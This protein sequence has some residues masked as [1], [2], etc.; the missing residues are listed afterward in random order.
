[1]AAIDWQT[2]ERVTVLGLGKSGVSVV[3][4]LVA[5]FADRLAAGSL[6]IQVLDSRTEPPGLAQA[7]QLLGAQ[8]IDCRRW[9][10]EDTLA[11]DL[12]VISPGVDS[13][14]ETIFLARQVGVQVVGDVELFA[15][16]NQQPCVGVT[17]SNGKSTVTRMVEFIAQQQGKNIVAAGNIGYPVLDALQQNV[18]GYV[19]EL[20]SF[21]LETTESLQLRAATVLNVSP[22]HL[23]R[24]QQLAD[25]A[26][27]KQ[28]IYRHA[29]CRVLN[30]Q[31]RQYW[32]QDTNNSVTFGDDE[33]A[34]DFALK[35]HQSELWV[36][37]QGDLLVGAHQLA[38]Q[39]LHNLL[40]V[41]AALA[42]AMGL[43]ID[44]RDAARQIIQFKGLPHRCQLVTHHAGIKWVNDSKATNVGATEAAISGLRPVVQGRLIVIMGGVGKGADFTSLQPALQQV[45]AL[46][47]IG[48]E[49]PAIGALF[50]GS[51]Q[52][53]S[54]DA[55]VKLA[56]SLAAD[57]DMVLLSPACASFDQFDDFE[58]RGQRFEQA[59]EA[60]YEQSA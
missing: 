50:N 43:A 11:A 30:R 8:A 57:G 25:Y 29:D 31:Q 42:L 48:E 9:Q 26:A 54:I 24:Y 14:D 53:D 10:L 60:L 4:Y 23:D 44:V 32:P 21:Q 22:D 37:Y 34:Q 2:I 36:T 6:R 38:V 33:Q 5:R 55:A 3:R 35:H 16:Q 27:A 18:D 17:G 51:R 49:G 20:S 7:Q 39:G 1:M 19:L 41:Q 40:N 45:D 28:R 58:H 12:L 15:Q 46:I 59:V 47:T 56:S 52:V 13:R